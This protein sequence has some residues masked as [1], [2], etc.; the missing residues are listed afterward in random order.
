MENKRNAALKILLIEDSDTDAY[1]VQRALAGHYKDAECVRATTLHAGMELLQKNGIDLLL[2]DL[3]LP[4]TAGPEDTYHQVKQWAEKMPVVIL[5][6]VKDHTLA[7]TMVHDGAADFVNKDM[8]AHDA[9]QI[10]RAVDF[11]LE[12]HAIHKK[13]AAESQEK[14]TILQCFMGGYSISDSD[15]RQM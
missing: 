5:T 12:R 4:D 8:I 1:I 9:A 6:N 14:D 10:R 3:G 11:S 2:L 13:L 15:H 7:K